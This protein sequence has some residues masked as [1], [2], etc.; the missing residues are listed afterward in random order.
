MAKG[1]F[2]T[3]TLPPAA[4]A[5]GRIGDKGL[6][7]RVAAPLR[8]V[9]AGTRGGRGSGG[10]HAAR[11]LDFQPHNRGRRSGRSFGHARPAAPQPR[12][13][14][15]PTN[16]PLCVYAP[17]PEA[18][19]P[20][21]LRTLIGSARRPHRLALGVPDV[22]AAFPLSYWSAELPIRQPRGLIARPHG[23]PGSSSG[24]P[25][26]LPGSRL[27]PCRGG[28]GGARAISSRFQSASR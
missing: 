5:G 6:A 14:G 17:A 12:H 26:V 16:R 10:G 7:R 9:A 23:V 18:P 8:S 25:R 24:K 28:G 19:Q 4:T 3:Y 27:C 2:G 1:V 13:Y 22:R 20:V 15:A 11:G 21:A